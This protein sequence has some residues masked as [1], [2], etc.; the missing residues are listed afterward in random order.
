MEMKKANLSNESVG[1]NEDN[2]LDLLKLMLTTNPK[3]RITL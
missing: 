3:M 2:I 1:I